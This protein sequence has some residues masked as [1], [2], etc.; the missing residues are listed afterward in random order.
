MPIF[1]AAENKKCH[2]KGGFKTSPKFTLA[3]ITRPD[4]AAIVSSQ[5]LNDDMDYAR[6][7]EDTKRLWN[8]GLAA[9]S[10]KFYHFIHSFSTYDSITPRRLMR[11]QRSCAAGHSPT[12]SS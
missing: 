1:K 8:K 6:Q 12:V 4:K 7:L 5:Y 3:Y 10:R 9:N 2:G 11:S